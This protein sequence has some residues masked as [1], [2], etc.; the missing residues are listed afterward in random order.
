MCVGVRWGRQ[1]LRRVERAREGAARLLALPHRCL[2]PL[3]LSSVPTRPNVRYHHAVPRWTEGLGAEAGARAGERLAPDFRDG[4][5]TRRTRA[6]CSPARP[7]PSRLAPS[8]SHTKQ[9]TPFS[10]N[11]HVRRVPTQ[12]KHTQARTS[13]S[14]ATSSHDG[15]GGSTTASSRPAMA[16]GKNVTEVRGG[17]R[18]GVCRCERRDAGARCGAWTLCVARVWRALLFALTLSRA[19]VSLSPSTPSTPPCHRT[20]W[21]RPRSSATSR[22]RRPRSPGRVDGGGESCVVVSACCGRPKTRPLPPPL[23]PPRIPTPWPCPPCPARCTPDPH[24]DAASTLRWPR[25]GGAAGRRGRAR[26]ARSPLFAS[27]FN[28]LC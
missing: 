28:P 20:R 13:G 21:W 1:R 18:V 12:S 26:H 16:G 25:G 15:T 24:A 7:L 9:T 23:R 27:S 10:L 3:P 17:V 4:A 11:H 6:L 22:A 8:P 14:V 2:S 5:A 19:P